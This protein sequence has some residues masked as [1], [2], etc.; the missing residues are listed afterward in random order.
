MSLLEKLSC[1]LTGRVSK[2]AF[3]AVLFAQH[4]GE[5]GVT[6]VQWCLSFL[7]VYLL[8]TLGRICIFMF[9]KLPW[10]QFAYVK[11]NIKMRKLGK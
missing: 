10:K 3:S 8:Y 2:V 4:R 5:S 1:V 9:Q 7:W 6:L 11:N